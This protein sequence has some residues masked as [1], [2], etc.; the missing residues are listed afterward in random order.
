[1]LMNCVHRLLLNFEVSSVKS[2]EE[3]GIQKPHP[4]R[5]ILPRI[6][7]GLKSCLILPYGKSV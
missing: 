2:D 1:M 4:I 5:Q 6:L 3:K 7:L